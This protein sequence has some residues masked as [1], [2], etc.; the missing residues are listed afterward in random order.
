MKGERLRTI[1]RRDSAAD[2]DECRRSDRVGGNGGSR[3]G[4]ER[5]S[6]GE[7][8]RGGAVSRG[9]RASAGARRDGSVGIHGGDGR[10]AESGMRGGAEGGHY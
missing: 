6:R 9:R 3:K 7:R 5:I 10:R 4:S 2:A 1:L 8:G